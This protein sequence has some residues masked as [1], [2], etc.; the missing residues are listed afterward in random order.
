MLF[1]VRL[2]TTTLYFLSKYRES[3][4][5]H[6]CS[7]KSNSINFHFLHPLNHL[8]INVKFHEVHNIM[9]MFLIPLI[10]VNCSI[11]MTIFSPNVLNIVSITIDLCSVNTSLHCLIDFQ[12]TL[13]HNLQ[14]LHPF[15]NNIPKASAIRLLK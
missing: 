2:Y 10:P 8:L 3:W 1:L 7:D 13:R 14:Y 9:R 12:Y 5:H 4:I 11:E 6:A 15:L